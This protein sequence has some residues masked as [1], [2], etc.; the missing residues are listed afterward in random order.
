[1]GDGLLR[2]MPAHALFPHLDLDARPP[3]AS[4][5]RQISKIDCSAL[6]A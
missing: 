6:N 1:V 4:A 3:G 2:R 5:I